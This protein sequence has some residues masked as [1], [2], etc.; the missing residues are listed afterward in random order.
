LKDSLAEQKQIANSRK[1]ELEASQ[2]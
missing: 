2:A 1:T